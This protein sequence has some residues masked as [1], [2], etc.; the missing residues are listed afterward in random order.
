MHLLLFWG[1]NGWM[2]SM[3]NINSQLSQSQLKIGEKK[4]RHKEMQ[5]LSISFLNLAT[6]TVF[7]TTVDLSYYVL[8]V[9]STVEILQNFVAFSIYMNFN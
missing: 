4:D 3:E 2:A 8:P 5:F 7:Q 1:D 6:F 9:K